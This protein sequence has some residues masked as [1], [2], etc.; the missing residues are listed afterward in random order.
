MHA[1]E[2]DRLQ[3]R[4]ITKTF[5]AVAANKDLNLS[6][7]AGEV[8]A[9]LGENGAGKSTL[10]NILYGLL[11]PDSGEI[12]IDGKQ[13]TI[14]SPC[15]A[16][17]HG[18]GMV[19]QHFMLV[20]T[21]SVL[22]NLLLM[23]SGESKGIFPQTKQVRARIEQLSQQY[24]LEVDPDAL[25]SDLTVGQQ[26]R[27]E[28]IKAVYSETSL[29]ILDE[30]TAV[31]TPS[32]TVDLF[33]IVRRLAQAGKS[34]IFISHKL[35]ELIQIS[36][37]ITVLRA[38]M[39][40]DTVD[41]AQT[42]PQELSYLMVG[43]KPD[44]QL[45]RAPL[46]QGEIILKVEDF[47]VKAKNGT[48]ALNHLGLHVRAGEIYGI[49]GVDGN[50]QSELIRAICAL[51]RRESGQLY[52]ADNQIQL[53]CAPDVILQQG[54]AH[55]P[56]DR[57]RIGTVM[58]MSVAEN[59]VLH[60]IDNPDFRSCGLLDWKKI[61]HYAQ[62][63]VENYDVRT[64]NVQAPVNALS[65]GNQQ[66]LVVAR[67]LGKNPKLLLAMHPTRGVDIGAIDFIHK[68]II[69]ARN[70]GCAVLLV[71]TELDEILALSDRI[72]VI[73]KGSILGEMPRSEISMEKIALWMAGHGMEQSHQA[74]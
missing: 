24:G 33:G 21:L 27:V 47:V 62:T 9:L 32:E 8:H 68:Q 16:I 70:R 28:I 50:G 52:L 6:V 35:N 49:A 34:V 43:K 26:Q 22:E 45:R 71:S 10:M 23:L 41:T 39:V 46:P 56:E 18:I 37:R 74:G 66:K 60:S 59:L 64:A 55:I 12:F 5:G 7:R 19:H 11:K 42:T 73:Y 3:L 36:H 65:G 38:G 61:N 48:R 31:L 72:G 13:V 4:S 57:Q 63:L 14:D 44:I 40:I 25:V 15:D 1:H 51:T 67:E 30:P 53:L 29:L 69:A 54:V 2:T 20:H 17:R 58:S